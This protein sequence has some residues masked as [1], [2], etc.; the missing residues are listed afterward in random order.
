MCAGGLII[1]S[2]EDERVFLIDKQLG[3]RVGEFEGEPAFRWRD[4]QGD[5]SDLYEF[6][7]TGTNRP[8]SLFFET[9]MYKAMWE[10]EYNRSA[11]VASEKDLQQ[12]VFS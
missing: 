2:A 7:A 10:R 3:F 12:F 5:V 1:G 8:T 11:E 6:V 4:I 9:C